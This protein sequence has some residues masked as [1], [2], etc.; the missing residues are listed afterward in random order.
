M[1]VNRFF[2]PTPMPIMNTYVPIDFSTLLQVGREQRQLVDQATKELNAQIMKFGEFQAPSEIDTQRWYDNTIGK[3]SDLLD[4]AASNPDAM[5]DANFRAQINSRLANLDYGYLS[6]MKQTADN[7]KARLAMIAQMKSKGLYNLNWDPLYNEDAIRRWDTATQG[8]MDN[9]APIEYKSLLDLVKPY[10]DNIK[11]TFY[12][13]NPL[14]G[15][16]LP[17]TN[18]MAISNDELQRELTTNF[19]TLKNTPQGS[20]WYNDI[21]RAVKA[22][23]PNATEADYDRAFMQ[24]LM[25]ESSYKLQATPVVDQATLS[26][27]KMANDREI[28][29]LR[30]SGKKR[31]STGGSDA[32]ESNPFKY[33]GNMVSIQKKAQSSQIDKLLSDSRY[34]WLKDENDNL[35]TSTEKDVR[36]FYTSAIAAQDIFGDTLRKISSALIK[37]GAVPKDPAE[38][39]TSDMNTALQLVAGYLPNDP[40]TQEYSDMYTGHVNAAW[41][42]NQDAQTGL[43]FSTLGA[44]FP[45]HENDNNHTKEYTD[46]VADLLSS[47]STNSFNAIDAAAKNVMGVDA[48]LTVPESDNIINLFFGNKDH[49]LTDADFQNFKSPFGFLYD[50]YDGFKNAVNTASREVNY[51]GKLNAKGEPTLIGNTDSAWFAFEKDNWSTRDKVA[52]GFFAN[53]G[54]KM[55]RVYNFTRVGDTNEF[56]FYATVKVPTNAI[57]E[58]YP[59]W[60]DYSDNAKDDENIPMRTETVVSVNEDGKS[61]SE[62]QDYLIVP[63]IIHKKLNAKDISKLDHMMTNSGKGEF[64]N[65]YQKDIDVSAGKEYVTNW[66]ED[67]E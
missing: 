48:E 6:R 8:I 53:K 63:T 14:T 25:T 17:Y 35:A 5:K 41:K 44:Y 45:N 4:E 1:E 36:E 40:T 7:S 13:K 43:V 39:T 10:V 32:S 37:N 20:L 31:P 65:Q 46:I 27:A 67:L 59:S 49:V 22:S 57:D 23:N 9:L 2:K 51:T 12:K 56:A 34:K 18:W 47:A 62:Q 38:W 64:S 52:D 26:L 15:E 61:V 24:A 11:P 42:F 66:P 60:Y 50:N 55:D 16:D 54:V 30:S 21:A 58:E 29:S 3:F 28:A 33:V 19:N